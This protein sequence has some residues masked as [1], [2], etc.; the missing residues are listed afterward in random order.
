MHTG[1]TDISLHIWLSHERIA[2]QGGNL[3]VIVA[4]LL[5]DIVQQ[6]MRTRN[7][8]EGLS[9]ALRHVLNPSTTGFMVEFATS[10]TVL[11][12]AQT[13]SGR[14]TAIWFRGYTDGIAIRDSDG[15]REM[16]KNLD[17]W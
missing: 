14:S 15:D 9:R 12:M 10:R 6:K 5:T 1:S 3:Q 2:A 11:R 8:D 13:T 17:R 7:L 4:N 16:M